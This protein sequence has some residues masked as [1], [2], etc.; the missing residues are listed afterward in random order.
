[1]NRPLLLAAGAVAAGGFV[2][3][4]ARSTSAPATP[5]PTLAFHPSVGDAAAPSTPGG[6]AA[7]SSSSVGDDHARMTPQEEREM[8]I[9]IPPEMCTKE[10]EKMNTL[11]GRAP[12]DPIVLN[13]VSY[14]FRQGN[15]AWARCI[16]NATDNDSV[17]HCNTRF[18]DW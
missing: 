5:Q 6:S 13:V 17:K 14:C 10:G 9:K 8:R 16:D 12:T 7:A 1:M 4:A 18:M 3:L 2:Y 11:A 15:V